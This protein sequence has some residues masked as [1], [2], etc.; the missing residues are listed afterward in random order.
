M[1]EPAD[2]FNDEDEL[3]ELDGNIFETLTNSPED[4]DVTA[5]DDAEK[6]V[7]DLLWER[8]TN[9]SSNDSLNENTIEELHTLY[10]SLMKEDSVDELNVPIIDE[11]H[12]KISDLKVVMDQKRTD[13]LWIQFMDFVSIV[14]MFICAERTGNWKLHLHASELMLPFFAAAGHNKYAKSIPKYLQDVS[15]LCD[16]L[17]KK[18]EKKR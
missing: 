8:S 4:E 6:S 13:K 10:D 3:L 12:E 2:T 7:A 16:C 9:N 17:K 14:R 18:Y 1:F 5:K 11:I 15:N